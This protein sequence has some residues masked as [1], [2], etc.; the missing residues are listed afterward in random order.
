MNNFQSTGLL[1]WF[2]ENPVAANLLMA[3]LFLGG[4]LSLLH[5]DKQAFPK[6]DPPVISISAEYPGAGPAEVEEGVCIPI[7]EVIHDLNGIKQIK[8]IAIDG[9]CKIKVLVE[10]DFDVRHLVSNLRAR[11]ESLRNLPKAVER[12]N[13]DDYSWETPA[14]TVVLRGHTDQLTLRH[15]A[16]TVRDELNQ[17]DGVRRATLWNRVAYEIA[18]EVPAARLKQHQLTLTDVAKAVRNSSLDL[19]GGEMKAESGRLQLRSKY[20]AYDK[21]KLTSLILLTRPDGSVVRLGDIATITDGFA[22]VHFQNTSDGIPSESISVV[23]KHDLVEVAN[24]VTEFVNT[25][26]AQMP[27]GVEIITRRDNARSFNELLDRLLTSK[28]RL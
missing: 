6:F 24:A 12:I 18:I 20:T 9:E 17:L 4:M 16:E 1:A 27:E 5:M 14:I 3:I 25:L 28:V 15:L 22:D 8:I 13:I 23:P 10:Q 21:E 7:E 2:A 26:S 19:S 11:T